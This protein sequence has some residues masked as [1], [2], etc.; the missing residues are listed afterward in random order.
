MARMFKYEEKENVVLPNPMSMDKSIVR[1]SIL[2]S[3]IGTYEYNKSRKVSDVLLYEI[4]KVYDVNYTED[5]KIAIL[6]KGNYITNSWQGNTKIDFYLV[7]GIVENLLD[8]LGLKNRYGFEIG[9]CSDLHPGMSANI[10][11]DRESIGIFGRVH[12]SFLKDEVYV[13]EI[14]LG[15]IMVKKIKPIKYKESS[16][17]PAISKD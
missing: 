8:Y 5:T 3:L 17:Y 9:T 14:S 16:R 6:M 13:V 11:L 4:S 10:L 12:P 7:K 15:K 1:T 2:P